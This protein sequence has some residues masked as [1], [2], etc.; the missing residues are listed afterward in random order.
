M[1]NAIKIRLLGPIAVET[2][3]GWR[4]GLSALAAPVRP[5][6][7]WLAWMHVLSARQGATRAGPSDEPAAFTAESN[8]VADVRLAGNEI[9]RRPDLALHWDPN[10]KG[11][12]VIGGLGGTAPDSEQSNRATRNVVDTVTLAGNAVAGE[13]D[14]FAVYADLGASASQNTARNVTKSAR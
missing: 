4:R 2:P 12:T 1:R 14:D 8:R 13:V 5:A 3:V 7:R 6:G 11:I 9:E 10:V